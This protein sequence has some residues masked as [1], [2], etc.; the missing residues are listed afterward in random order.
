MKNRKIEH[1]CN[2]AKIYR[3]YY[4]P[5]FNPIRF[6]RSILGVLITGNGIAAHNYVPGKKRGL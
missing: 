1:A 2:E 3:D 5:S 4:R 6:L